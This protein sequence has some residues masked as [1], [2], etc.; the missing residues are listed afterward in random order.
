MDTYFMEFDEQQTCITQTK[1][2]PTLQSPKNLAEWQ[3]TIELRYCIQ[4]NAGHKGAHKAQDKKPQAGKKWV[5]K[6][7]QLQKCSKDE[8]W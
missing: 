3:E 8:K 7:H 6:R 4:E 5:I 2:K 1:A